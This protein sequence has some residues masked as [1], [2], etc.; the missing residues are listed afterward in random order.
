MEV[1]DRKASLFG[2]QMGS[3]LC[4]DLQHTNLIIREARGSGKLAGVLDWDNAWAGPSGPTSP[5]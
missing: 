2:D 5:E 4:D 3:T 1:L